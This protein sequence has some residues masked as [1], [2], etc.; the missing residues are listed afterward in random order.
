LFPEGAG[1]GVQ[2]HLAALLLRPDDD[3]VNV[4]ACGT[5]PSHRVR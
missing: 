3:S 4:G 2:Q 1:G 5:A